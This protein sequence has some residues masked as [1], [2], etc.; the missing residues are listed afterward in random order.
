MNTIEGREEPEQETVIGMV[1]PAAI[2]D[3]HRDML[4]VTSELDAF[5]AFA[6]TA[7]TALEK[8]AG[9]PGNS[10]ERVIHR[11]FYNTPAAGT[12]KYD[13]DAPPTKAMAEQ[14]LRDVGD[15][16][17]RLKEVKG[18]A[19]DEGRV[20]NSKGADS[21]ST[22][23]LE[24]VR[25]RVGG[26]E[27]AAMRME[28]RDGR[29]YLNIRPAS[30]AVAVSGLIDILQALQVK[31]QVKLTY[32]V[33]QRTLNRIDRLVLY[34]EEGDEKKAVQAVENFY[35]EQSNIFDDTGSPRFTAPLKNTEG[36][37]MTGVSFGEEPDHTVVGA[38]SFGGVRSKILADVCAQAGRQ[39]VY[40]PKFDIH[41]AFISACKRSTIAVDSSHPAFNSRRAQDK[42]SF[43]FIRSRL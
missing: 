39:R 31:A 32:G 26:Y 42:P 7:E 1:V 25:F 3:A 10:L 4:R 15:C 5:K 34:F 6:I 43:E 22:K 17:E 16:I 9:T 18:V 40:D 12:I 23:S 21:K 13:T 30:A 24:Q 38:D 19:V 20:E 35:R 8:A 29:V 28:G 37:L 11:E 14:A 41:S 2:L 36:T 27:P 33:S